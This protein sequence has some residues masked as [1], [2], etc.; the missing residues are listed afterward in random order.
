MYLWDFLIPLVGILFLVFIWSRPERSKKLTR[1]Q[2]NA[3]LSW[4][5]QGSLT[6]K[7]FLIAI[8]L[9]IVFWFIKD[10]I[11]QVYNGYIIL[12]I[13]FVVLAGILKQ[14]SYHERVKKYGLPE[15]PLFSRDAKYILTV[16]VI[17]IILFYLF[18]VFFQR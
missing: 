12:I 11:P 6:G 7:F 14:L 4:L 8:V 18:G 2:N 3:E 15:I 16:G 5:L 1:K 13:I 17:V 10:S 9:G